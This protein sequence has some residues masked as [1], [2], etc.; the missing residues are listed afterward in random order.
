MNFAPGVPALD[1][2]VL[3][4]REISV[5]GITVR[6]ASA[7]LDLPG[8]GR[9]GVTVQARVKPRSPSRLAASPT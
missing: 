1:A 8:G 6:D 7:R 4:V 2:V 3:E 5:A 9:T